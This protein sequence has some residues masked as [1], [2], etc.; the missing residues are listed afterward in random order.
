MGGGRGRPELCAVQL[1]CLN[2]LAAGDLSG[3][4]IAVNHRWGTM[5]CT[6]GALM[7]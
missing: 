3:V 4:P 5:R 6:A 2:H 1:L 7:E